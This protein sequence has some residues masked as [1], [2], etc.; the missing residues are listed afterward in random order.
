MASMG[1]RT[2]LSI[3]L[4]VVFVAALSAQGTAVVIRVKSAAIDSKD[5]NRMVL[6]VNSGAQVSVPLSDIDTAASATVVGKSQTAGAGPS[7]RSSSAVRAS[8]SM[9]RAKCEKDWPTDVQLRALC[10][11]TQR[12]SVVK[13]SGRT[14]TS[15]EQIAIRDKCSEEWPN[16][17]EMRN[18]C[19]EKQLE[20]LKQLG[21]KPR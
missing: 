11:K 1:L 18:V 5:P 14:M 20:A 3:W 7:A 12:E 16:D 19:E 4:A 15:A 10:E 17:F 9:I 13:L 21:S 2:V 8:D 6:T